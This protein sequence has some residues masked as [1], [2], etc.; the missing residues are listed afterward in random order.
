MFLLVAPLS[1]SA[2]VLQFTLHTSSLSGPAASLAFDFIDGDGVLGNNTAVISGFS[3]D[4][5]LDNDA[6]EIDGDVSGTLNPGPMTLMDT[7]FSSFLQPLA[8]GTTLSFTLTLTQQSDSNGDLPD[9]FAFFLLDPDTFLPLFK[10]TDPT[11]VG[12]L[13]AVDIDGS[14]GGELLLFEAVDAEVTWIVE[15]VATVPLP[16]TVLLI[17]AGLLGGLAARRWRVA[18][19]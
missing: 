19:R 9:S 10:T 5:T 2:T 7:G 17:G 11:D 14:S 8:L 3:T 15:P 18:L 13:F 4:G 16:S 1:A 6:V 12:A